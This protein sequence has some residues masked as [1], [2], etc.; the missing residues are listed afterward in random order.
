MMNV[1]VRSV[2]HFSML[3]V[4]HLIKTKGNIVNVSSVCGTRAFPGVLAYCMS[5]SAIDQLTRCTALELADKGVKIELLYKFEGI[6]IFK[7]HSF[8]NRSF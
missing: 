6:Q 3:A 4:P 2:Y 1:N 5:K 7:S 8:S